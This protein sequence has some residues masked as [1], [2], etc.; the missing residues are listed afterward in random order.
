MRKAHNLENQIYVY[1]SKRFNSI[2]SQLLSSLT[3]PR[4]AL[5]LESEM[6]ADFTCMYAWAEWAYFI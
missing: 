6:N 2:C 5:C 1:V 3:L 4:S